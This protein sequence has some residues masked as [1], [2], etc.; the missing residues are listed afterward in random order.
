MTPSGPPR[1]WRHWGNFA[2]WFAILLL[3]LAGERALAG[4]VAAGA[5]AVGLLLACLRGLGLWRVGRLRPR[6]KSDLPRFN[7]EDVRP[8][9]FEDR[10]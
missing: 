10:D 8:S 1:A 9:D 3:M 7:F 4:L 5:L 2:I 6:P